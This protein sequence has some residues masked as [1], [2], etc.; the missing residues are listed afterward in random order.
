MSARWRRTSKN[1]KW[2]DFNGLKNKKPK[3]NQETQRLKSMTSHPNFRPSKSYVK[4][5]IV[6]QKPLIDIFQENNTITI[7]AEIVGFNR[8][9]LK[10]TVKDQ[11]ITLSAKSKDRRYYKSLN[12][13]TAV[14]PNAMH[15]KFKNGVLEIKLQKAET[16]DKEANQN[17]T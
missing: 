5:N 3:V 14:I 17:A 12:L 1:R 7:V 9:T 15:T 8:E 11:K 6:E 13:P 2:L 4:R 10:I 16:L